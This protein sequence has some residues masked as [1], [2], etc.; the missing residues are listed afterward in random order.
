MEISGKA[1]AVV[2][3]ASGMAKATAEML[4][5]EGA[6]VSILDL[7]ASIRLDGGLRFAPK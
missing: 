5:R 7:P 6:Q 2:G 4:A 3:G 1:A